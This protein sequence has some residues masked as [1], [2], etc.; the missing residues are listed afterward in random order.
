MGIKIWVD[1]DLIVDHL[2]KNMLVND[3]TF[4]TY[5][6]QQQFLEEQRLKNN[7]KLDEKRK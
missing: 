4:Y 2:G 5:N 1:S 3:K 7:N 6:E